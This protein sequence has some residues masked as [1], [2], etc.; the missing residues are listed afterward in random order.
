MKIELIFERSCPNIQ[1][2]RDQLQQALQTAGQD[3]CWQEWESSDP[4]VPDYV[5]AYGSPTILVNGKDVSGA[6]ATDSAVCCRIY[7]NSESA[8]RGVPALADIVR[9]L[10]AA[11]GG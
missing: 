5:R 7:Q 11:A 8:N 10:H 4:A 1:A 2:A 6:K 9:A 3:P